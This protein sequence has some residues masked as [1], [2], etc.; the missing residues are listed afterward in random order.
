MRRSDLLF[1]TCCLCGFFIYETFHSLCVHC[2][3]A[4]YI[5]SA[6]LILDGKI[7]YVDIVDTN[8]PLIMYLHVI[9]EYLALHL[10]INQILI[11][12]VF[13]LGISAYCICMSTSIL[14]SHDTDNNYEIRVI[15]LIYT[16]VSLQMFFANDFGQREQ[17]FMAV[18]LPFLFMRFQKGEGK[19]FRPVVAM[20]VG[21]ISGIGILLKPHFIL[22]AAFSEICYRIKYRR[23]L[24]VA[25]PELIGTFIA[26]IMY[27]LHFIFIPREMHNGLFNV[28]L[29]LVSQGYYTNNAELMRIFISNPI[30]L[31]AILSVVI[32]LAVLRVAPPS[33]PQRVLLPAFICVSISGVALVLLQGKGWSYHSI[34][35]IYSSSIIMALG[36]LFASHQRG[37][38]RQI[39]TGIMCSYKWFFMFISVSVI[40]YVMQIFWWKYTSGNFADTLKCVVFSPI[41]M[42][43]IVIC[44]QISD[45]EKYEIRAIG[46]A[47]NDSRR[48]IA[49]AIALMVITVANPNSA[50]ERSFK[51]NP[52]ANLINTNSSEGDS[53][54]ILADRCYPLLLQMNRR[55][56]T[57]FLS[58]VWPL[59]LIFSLKDQYGTRSSQVNV[60]YYFRLIGE[61]IDRI[62]PKLI[63]VSDKREAHK[64]DI[65]QLLI[66]SGLIQNQLGPYKRIMAPLGYVAFQRS[67]FSV[68]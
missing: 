9:P 45:I 66:E 30:L 4:L 44:L 25:S 63:I 3:V 10:N 41:L 34:P 32:G 38:V 19:R 68:D 1:L 43:F 58:S 28:W 53:V 57:R 21:F 13:V 37:V 12:Y 17:I 51:N 31:F 48:Y 39:H 42:S 5:E 27:L 23:Y 52:L 2:D 24:E 65:Y 36:C 56:G 67:H 26:C 14:V 64:F 54:M 8:L 55:C 16:V 7:P 59:D 22:I 6:R 29:P 61:D 20:I 50:I 15:L 40:I 60:G 18:Y 47:L 49:L 35:V 62:C 33:S 11:Y 46:T